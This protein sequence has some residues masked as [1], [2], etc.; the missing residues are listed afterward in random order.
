MPGP[1]S[2]RAPAG[3]SRHGVPATKGTLRILA[4]PRSSAPACGLGKILSKAWPPTRKSLASRASLQQPD[5]LEQQ[6]EP[7]LQSPVVLTQG[8]ETK[9]RHLFLFRDWLVI[10]K[11]RS[12]KSYGLKQK[13]PLSDLGVVSCDTGEE[14]EEDKDGGLITRGGNAIFFIM[15]SDPC[16]TEF[17]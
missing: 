10:A 12:S 1:Q 2:P 3:R 13:L 6:G 9:Q 11:R 7:I 16:V 14:Q 5:L 8:P 15:A 4:Q 17:P